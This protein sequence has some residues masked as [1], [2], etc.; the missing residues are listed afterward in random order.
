MAVAQDEFALSLM[1]VDTVAVKQLAFG[2][3]I[4][5]AGIAGG[6]LMSSSL[7]I[8]PSAASI[9]VASLQSVCSAAWAA[10]REP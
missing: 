6:F 2:V 4:A 10:S 3:A 8:R 5:T 9:S 1:A 7:S